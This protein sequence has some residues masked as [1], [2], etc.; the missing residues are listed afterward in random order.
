MFCYK[1]W[2]AKLCLRVCSDTRLLISAIP[3]SGM[4]GTIE[5]ARRHRLRW[6]TAGE[7][8]ALGRAAFHQVRSRSSKL[9]DR[10]TLRSLPPL[11]CSTRMI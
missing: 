11:P 5:L 4:T 6:I 3:C 10:M 9:G 8:P 1:R 2:V 7:Q